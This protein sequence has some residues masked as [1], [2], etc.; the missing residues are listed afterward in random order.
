MENNLITIAK[1]GSHELDIKKSRFISDIFRIQTEEDA[2]Q[3]IQEIKSH[4]HKANHHCFASVS[5]THLTLPT[6]ERV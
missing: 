5:Y 2:L 4:H 1:N 6:T 3:F